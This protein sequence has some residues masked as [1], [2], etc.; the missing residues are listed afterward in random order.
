MVLI[1]VRQANSGKY[2]NI[3][4]SDMLPLTASNIIRFNNHVLLRTILMLRGASRSSR[5]EM[6]FKKGVFKDFTKLT[7][8]HLCQRLFF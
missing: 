2:V 8:K 7:G 5:P 1:K 3:R 4:N 6:F